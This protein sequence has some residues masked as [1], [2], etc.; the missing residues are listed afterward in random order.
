MALRI[1]G[2]SFLDAKYSGA[3]V[4]RKGPS[5]K[6]AINKLKGIL[7][8]RALPLLVENPVRTTLRVFKN[9]VAAFFFAVVG[10]IIAVILVSA[11]VFNDTTTYVNGNNQA[12][13]DKVA[14]WSA[15]TGLAIVALAVLVFIA[16]TV[17]S[18]IRAWYRVGNRLAL[19]LG[20]VALFFF[21]SDAWR[22][23]G[24]INW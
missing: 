8:R 17:A 22:I 16:A 11:A 14:H 20:F 7:I 10:I 24:G 9:S 2:R 18:A 12:L 5:N 13:V 23:A 15:W 21:S 1:P 19:M 3:V 6:D 4:S